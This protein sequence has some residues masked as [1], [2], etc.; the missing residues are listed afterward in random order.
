MNDNDETD[1]DQ[2]NETPLLSDKLN[3]SNCKLSKK[4][5]KKEKELQVQLQ[6]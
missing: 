2:K 4:K 5:E 6:K 1:T 3:K